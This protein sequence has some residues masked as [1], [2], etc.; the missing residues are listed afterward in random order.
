MF[1]ATNPLATTCRRMC[2]WYSLFL[3][4]F[5]L[6][7]RYRTRSH[8]IASYLHCQ[9]KACQ[10]SISR[11]IVPAFIAATF[12][13][14]PLPSLAKKEFQGITRTQRHHYLPLLIDDGI[15]LRPIA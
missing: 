10:F 9:R 6:R 4:S 5:A 8:L 14:Y 2:F 12:H 11:H 1:L 7:S 15:A 3:R 13:T